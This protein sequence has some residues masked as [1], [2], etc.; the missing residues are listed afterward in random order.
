[1][2]SAANCMSSNG[3]VNEFKRTRREADVVCF[4]LLSQRLSEETEENQESKVNQKP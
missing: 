1:M 4:D 3:R 2:M